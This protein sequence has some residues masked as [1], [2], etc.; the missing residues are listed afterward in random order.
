M[1][2][3]IL[4]SV[5]KVCGLPDSYTP[6]DQDVVMFI[7]TAFGTL[8]QLGVGPDE[9][10]RIEDREALWTQMGLPPK[11]LD[12]VRTW[13]FLKVRQMFDP[14]QTSY[15]IEAMNKQIDQLEWRMS[16]NREMVLHPYV[17]EVVIHDDFG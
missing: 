14:P 17:E 13:T 8:E 9:G 7:N 3:S 16:V 5:K 15:L 2:D 10:F 6:F 11:Q 4:A 12:L 1:E